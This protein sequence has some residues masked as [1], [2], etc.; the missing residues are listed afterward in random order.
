MPGPIELSKRLRAE[1]WK[2][3][4]YANERLEPPHLT[5]ICREMVWRIG[6]RERDFMLPPGGRWKDI[7]P[8]I[9]TILEQHWDDLCN[10]WD[11]LHPSNPVSSE[12]N[13]DE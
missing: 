12:E 2:V 13:E 8:E 11:E 9:R 3:K 5:L 1:G 10:A 4:I 7:D 6:L